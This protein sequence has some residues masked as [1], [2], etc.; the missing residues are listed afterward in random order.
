VIYWGGRRSVLE[1]DATRT[2][3]IDD[4]SEIP[5]RRIDTLLHVSRPRTTDP[6]R[7]IGAKPAAFCRWLFHDLLGAQHGDTLDD[8]FPGS[9]G[10]QRAWETYLS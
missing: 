1:L 2:P 7:V 4:A 8:L 3:A 6:G 10:I 9:G 5:A